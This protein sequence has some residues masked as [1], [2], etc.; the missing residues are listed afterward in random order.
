[1]KALMAV[2]LAGVMLAGCAQMEAKPQAPTT[3]EVEAFVE[4]AV[5]YARDRGKEEALKTFTA[6]GG[7]FHRGQLYIYAYDF[8]CVCLAHGLQP[9]LVGKDLTQHRDSRGLLVIQ[10]L[11]EIARRGK[12]WLRFYWKSPE[13]G[14]EAAKLGYVMKVDDTWWLGSGTYGR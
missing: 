5:A 1:M 13:T 6:P 9:E 7:L 8:N 10:K 11:A 4:E 14:K 12:G 3:A 2:V